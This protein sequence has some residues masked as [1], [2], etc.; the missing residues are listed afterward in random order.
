MQPTA[1]YTK[2]RDRCIAT[3]Y[4]SSRGTSRFSIRVEA[5]VESTCEYESRH[6][7]AYKSSRVSAYKSNKSSHMSAYK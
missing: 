6:M 5:Q 7:S 1:M 2:D 4:K 3:A